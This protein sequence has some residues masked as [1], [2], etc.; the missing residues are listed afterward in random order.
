MSA[1]LM[2]SLG[3]MICGSLNDRRPISNDDDV[4]IL[5]LPDH[6]SLSAVE[7][8]ADILAGDDDTPVRLSMEMHFL[9]ILLSSV[10]KFRVFFLPCFYM[11]YK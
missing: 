11:K 8:I 5:I 7:N 3:G 6:E 4:V 1:I 9:L 10:V 2:E